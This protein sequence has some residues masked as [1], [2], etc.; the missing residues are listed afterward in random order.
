MKSTA[1]RIF[2]LALLAAASFA[3]AS[4]AAQEQAYG[5]VD[6]PGD[7]PRPAPP[8]AIPEALDRAAAI[9]AASHPMVAAAEAESRALEAEYRGARWLSYPSLTVDALAAVG[10]SQ[11]ADTDGLALNVA[12]EQPLWT[13]GRIGAEIDRA[14]ASLSAGE[15]RVAEAERQIA[16]DVTSAYYEYVLATERASVLGESLEQHQ[17]LIGSI[18]RR[19]SQEVSP[20]ADLTLGRSRTA[21]VELD[22]ASARELQERSAARLLELTGGVRVEPTMPPAG[23][24]SSLPPV[25]QALAEALACSPTLQTLSDLIDVAEAQRRI[26]RGQLFPQ[27]L[28]QLSQNEITGARAAVV[29]RAQTGNG[30]SRLTA[31][32][33][34]NARIQRAI[35]EFGDTERRLREQLRRDYILVE[36]AQRRITAGVLAADTADDIIESYQRQFIAGRRSWLDV[37]NAVREAASARLTESDARVTAAAAAARILATSCR[38]EPAPA[39]TL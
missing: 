5:P 18:E 15:D 39:E 9:A 8:P 38:W 2:S 16:L 29:L 37:M 14:R 12:L 27:V 1:R 22:L 6:V 11:Y 23:V 32:E 25:E 31:I 21:Q 30:L 19:V 20:L 35:A 24:A 3:G 7:R 33:S 34:A 36:S 26:A 4:V 13:G 10:G 17:T 28:L